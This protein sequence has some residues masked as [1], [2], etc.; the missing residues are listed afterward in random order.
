LDE[1][2]SHRMI[3]QNRTTGQMRSFNPYRDMSDLA[4][5]IETAFADELAITGSR[6][7]EDL[8]QMALWGPALPVVSTLTSLF[9]GVVWV[10]RG[11]LVGNVSISVD[12][13][14]ATWT[15][16]NVAVLPEFRGRGIAGQMVN[17][18][19]EQIR[20]RQGRRILLQVR[21]D[22]AAAQA[23]YK[24]RGFRI[25]DTWH[26][27]E[28]AR[29][30]WPRAVG[31][32]RKGLRGVRAADAHRL[33]RLAWECSSSKAREVRPPEA[34]RFR[35]GVWETVRRYA[36]ALCCGVH[37]FEVLGESGDAIVAFAALT[38]N[39]L[40]GP[41]EL[42]LQVAPQERGQWE[43]DLAVSVLEAAR[44]V[45]RYR[46]RTYT[47]ASHPQAV[48]SLQSLGFR[49]LRVLDQMVCD[50]G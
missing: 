38:A 46:V 44:S 2:M 5:L 15:M 48:A 30:Q 47:V 41:H 49:T 39:L 20:A 22:N 6:T 33:L 3:A 14:G 26:E 13:D 19:I 21:S 45:P 7:V 36:Q 16:S 4:L 37:Q 25:Y 42:V 9:G 18:A 29:Q 11:H 28:L 1:A 8:R 43:T 40:R 27:L 12:K 34:R 50:V 23:L 35:R 17:M 24:H 10:E 31:P 32:L